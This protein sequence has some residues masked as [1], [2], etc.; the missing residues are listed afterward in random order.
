M[1]HD[2]KRLAI[3]IRGAREAAGMSQVALAEAAGV[4]EGSIQNLESGANRTRIPPSLAKIEPILGWAT[5]SGLAIL[6][7]REAVTTD[8]APAQSRRSPTKL[9][10]RIV[11]ELESDDPLIDSTVIELPGTDGAR[12]T[13]VVHGRPDATPEEIQEALMAWR[14][15]ERRLRQLDE[16]Q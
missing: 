15:A 4:S 12:M 5:G 7:G 14:N 1:D 10:L 3:A 2:W 11:D 9:P 16:G 8:R 13:V 6:R